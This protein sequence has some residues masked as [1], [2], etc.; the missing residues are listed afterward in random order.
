MGKIRNNTML[1]VDELWWE[2]KNPQ[3]ILHYWYPDE[4]TR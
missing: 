1:A 4:Q 3:D 2:K